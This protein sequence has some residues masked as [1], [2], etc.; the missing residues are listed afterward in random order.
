MDYETQKHR[1]LEAQDVSFWLK[2]AIAELERRDPLDAA[3]DSRLL[4]D[5]MVL[6]EVEMLHRSHRLLSMDLHEKLGM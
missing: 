5:L 6:R 1:I 4:T 3:N 2:K